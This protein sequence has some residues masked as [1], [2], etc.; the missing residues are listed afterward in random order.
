MFKIT[1]GG[2]EWSAVS[3]GLSR[4]YVSALV[5]DPATPTTLCAGTA[6][7]VFDRQQEEYRMYLPLMGR[8]Q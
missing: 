5:I 8:A 3:D 7:G 6:G 4:T 2:G 1:N